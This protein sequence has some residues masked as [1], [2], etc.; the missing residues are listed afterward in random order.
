MTNLDQI[1]AHQV[2]NTPRR[3]DQ[4]RQIG[5]WVN[6]DKFL[7]TILKDTAY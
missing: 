6:W 4:S 3:L 2:T 1:I 7:H 5:T